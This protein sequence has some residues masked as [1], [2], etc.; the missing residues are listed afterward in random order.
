MRR[1]YPASALLVSVMILTGLLAI[2]FLT[3]QNWLSQE[4]ISRYYYER[5]LNSK[6][7]LAEEF[8]SSSSKYTEECKAKYQEK[9]AKYGEAEVLEIKTNKAVVYRIYCRFYSLFLTDKPTK[10]AVETEDISRY[11]ER[12]MVEKHKIEISDLAELP[13]NSMDDPKIVVA[14]QDLDGKLNADFYGIIITSHRLQLRHGAKFYG[15]LYTAYSEDG[16]SRYITHSAAA[17]SNLEKQHSGWEY[18][19]YSRNILSHAKTL[20]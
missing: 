8:K 19:P 12:D 18:L 4:N 2:I 1:Y 5:Y 14:T 6:W 3:K 17:M 11:L 13:A 16:K 7:S 15:T 10:K 9:I 20:H